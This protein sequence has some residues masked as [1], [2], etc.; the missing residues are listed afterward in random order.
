MAPST[1]DPERVAG[2]VLTG[3]AGRRMGGPKHRLVV[4]GREL[5]G[6]VAEA[7]RDAGCRPVVQVGSVDPTPGYPSVADRWPGEG[8]VGG[9]ITALA[10]LRTADHGSIGPGPIDE[11]VIAACDLP[12]LDAATVERLLEHPM[13]D[14]VGALGAVTA[15]YPVPLARWRTARLAQLERAFDAGLR[16]WRAALDLVGAE[17]IEV[18]SATTVDVDSPGDLARWSDSVR[19]MSIPEIDVAALAQA[20][21][22]G[23]R[24]IDVRE[25]DEYAAVHVP[26][27]Q[28][29]P[30]GTVPE[31]LDRFTG[32][33]PT[34][35]IC[36]S[37]AR[38]MRAC[39]FVAEHTGAEVV[40]VAGGTNAWVESGRTTASGGQ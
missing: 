37:G 4:G 17:L 11:V 16:S 34:Y 12:G 14:A 36:R 1:A 22:S 6:R 27:A 3:G 40:N 15:G 10:H 18:P 5:A 32:D 26:G 33:G 19:T 9:I 28:L 23:A 7:L 25:P 39:E 20:L 2:V 8:P 30:L 38:S 31:H 29:V 13:A 21:E 35:V 24:L